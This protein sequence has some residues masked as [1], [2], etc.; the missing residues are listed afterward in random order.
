MSHDKANFAQLK[1]DMERRLN[2]NHLL[3]T[4][5][6]YP[7]KK[8]NAPPRA[9]EDIWQ[10]VSKRFSRTN[11]KSSTNKKQKI[12]RNFASKI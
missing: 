9:T 11:K 8:T 4:E 7:A 12:Q 2:T 6:T 3:P 5:E 1:A 10:R